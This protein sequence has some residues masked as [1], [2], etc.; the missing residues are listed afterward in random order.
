MTC[1]SYNDCN[2]H[3]LIEN[4]PRKAQ[5]YVLK[6]YFISSPSYQYCDFAKQVVYMLNTITKHSP[7][8]HP[9]ALYF[10]NQTPTYLPC[11]HHHHRFSIFPPSSPL[12]TNTWLQHFS[13]TSKRSTLYAHDY[14]FSSISLQSLICVVSQCVISFP[15]SPACCTSPYPANAENLRISTFP[16]RTTFYAVDFSHS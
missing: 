14:I 10:E 7:Y 6:N 11:Y 15:G 13:S 8:T 16:C 3:K 12:F 2:S 4:I 9:P 1:S 5:S